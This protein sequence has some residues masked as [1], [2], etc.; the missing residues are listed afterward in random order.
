MTMSI[1]IMFRFRKIEHIRISQ[2]T[3]ITNNINETD[4]QTINQIDSNYLNT[5]KIA[6]VIFNPTPSLT[7]NYL[8]RIPEG[9]IDNVIPGLDILLTYIQSE[10]ATLAALRNSITNIKIIL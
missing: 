6:T 8:R 3:N 10:Y 9:I 5:N 7:E 1:M 2:Q 4:T